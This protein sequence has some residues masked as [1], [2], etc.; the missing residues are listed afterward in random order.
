[1]LSPHPSTPGAATTSAGLLLATV[2]LVAGCGGNAPCPA[3]SSWDPAVGRC[4]AL[5]HDGAL[6]DAGAAD[7][8][9]DGDL[10]DVG[11]LELGPHD[12]GRDLGPG[13]DLG[14]PDEGTDGGEAC[15]GAC[16]GATPVCEPLTETCVACLDDGDCPSTA[17]QC[18][19]TLQC[20]GCLD[21][22]DCPTGVC[23]PA[24][25]RCVECLTNASCGHLAASRC[26]TTTHAC[27][28]CSSD[29]DCSH[30]PG[31]TVCIAGQCGPCRPSEGDHCGDY[32]CSQVTLQCTDHR[33][34]YTDVYGECEA[35]SECTWGPCVLQ[36]FVG[37]DRFVCTAE[38]YPTGCGNFPVYQLRPSIHGDLVDACALRENWL[39]YEAATLWMHYFRTRPSTPQEAGYQCSVSSDCGFGTY[40]R[41]M[42]FLGQEENTSHCTVTGCTDYE[43]PP[44]L[45]CRP[46]PSGAPNYCAVWRF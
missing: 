41:E 35:S 8:A 14:A 46:G 15:G 27:V 36:S 31:R 40:C 29:G 16:A 45:I 28:P 21:H 25:G 11:V 37:P 1:M 5:P 17:P 32:S 22:N 24:S 4:V 6:A 3:G 20:V 18:S 30:I 13:R 42:H 44:G 23:E 19:P 43:C 39:T 2:L 10:V 9:A 33:R 38:H 34:G 26:E 7:A 12:G